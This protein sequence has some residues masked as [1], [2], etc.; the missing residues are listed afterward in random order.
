MPFVSEA[1][2]ESH[3]TSQFDCGKPELDTWLRLHAQTTEARRTG[4]TFVW[5]ED[6]RVVAYYTLAAHLLVRDE[7]PRTL[8]RGNPNQIPA[9]L[10]ARLALDKVLHGQG[11]GGALLADALQRVIVATET[12]AARFVVVDSI[13][14]AAC[15]FYEHHGFRLIPGTMRLVQKISDVAAAVGP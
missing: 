4:R 9:V 3:S 14:E 11:L 6:G 13:D 1:I 5:H 8:A 12:V 2:A 7:L 10:L 15:G